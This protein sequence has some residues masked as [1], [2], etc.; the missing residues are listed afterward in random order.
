MADSSALRYILKMIRSLRF[1]RATVLAGVAVLVV[2]C[3]SAPQTAREHSGERA[4]GAVDV[5]FASIV[6][7]PELSPQEVVDYQLR[8]LRMDNDQGFEIAFR[9]ASPANREMTG[10]VA[11]FAQMIRA[12]AYRPMLFF[13]RVTFF[14]VVY[15]DGVALQRVVLHVGEFLFMY[16]FFLRQQAEQGPYQ[17]CWMTEAVHGMMLPPRPNPGSPVPT[18]PLLDV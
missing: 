4:A 7:R 11:R 12:D 10:P 15:G 6:P 9:F 14:P 18:T 3:A 17:S 16:D 1:V 8:A 5:G 2:S 13:D